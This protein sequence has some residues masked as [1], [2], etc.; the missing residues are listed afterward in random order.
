MFLR[1]FGLEHLDFGVLEFHDLTA[2]DTYEM[3]MMSLG[4]IF[5]PFPAVTELSDLDKPFIDKQIQGAVYSGQ[6]D[7]GMIPGYD[8][9]EFLG[10]DMPFQ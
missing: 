1:H 10:A 9:V 7:L 8:V 4:A 2:F 3:V 6:P 5:I